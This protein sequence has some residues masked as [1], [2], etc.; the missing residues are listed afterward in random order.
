[1][2]RFEDL[3]C[4]YIC[5]Y[6]IKKQRYF[7]LSFFLSFSFPFLF[8][9][10]PLLSFPFLSFSSLLLSFSGNWFFFM[11]C[12]QILNLISKHNNNLTETDIQFIS[13]SL[14]TNFSFSD[15]AGKKKREETFINPLVCFFYPSQRFFFFLPFT[16]K[17]WRIHHS[18]FFSLLNK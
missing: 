11:Q 2:L 3:F 5:L 1:M 6:Q 7:F 9:S 4:A 16:K 15:I 17:I 14:T 13:S 10:S 18:I 12:N 8:L